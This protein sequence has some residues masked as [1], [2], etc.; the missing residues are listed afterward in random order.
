MNFFTGWRHKTL[1]EG[2]DGNSWAQVFQS[3]QSVAGDTAA[4]N[5]YKKNA[6]HEK[7][8][9]VA[10]DIAYIARIKSFFALANKK[11]K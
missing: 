2:N 9:K 11:E 8:I 6:N 7:R 1:N 3:P 10:I 5:N 4:N